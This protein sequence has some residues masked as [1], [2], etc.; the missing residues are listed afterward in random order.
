MATLLASERFGH[1]NVSAYQVSSHP[2]PFPCQRSEGEGAGHLT[3]F[4]PYSV[5]LVL[6][7]TVNLIPLLQYLFYAAVS[8]VLFC[9]VLRHSA[10][11]SAMGRR[12]CR[13]WVGDGV[14]DAVGGGIGD[15]V[16]DMVGR[17]GRRRGRRRGGAFRSDVG[18][19][20]HSQRLRSEVGTGS[21]TLRSRL[22]SPDR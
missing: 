17:G 11:G 6:S 20:T 8:P 18:L 12:W 15:R 14:S 1:P 13:R 7:S 16:G 19:A 5:F 21:A 22:L 3:Q 10:V 4:L 2:S 9:C